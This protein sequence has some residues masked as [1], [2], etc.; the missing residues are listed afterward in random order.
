MATMYKSYF[1]RRLQEAL[2]LA[3]QA[4]NE[5]ERSTHLRA[6]HYYRELLGLRR[7]L[8][9]KSVANERLRR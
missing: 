4:T 5:K 3:D 6:S 7:V 2:S 9:S 8:N 1:T